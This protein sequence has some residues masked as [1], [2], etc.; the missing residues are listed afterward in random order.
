MSY[1]REKR[2]RTAAF[3]IVGFLLTVAGSQR[4][5]FDW[6]LMISLSSRD[7]AFYPALSTAGFQ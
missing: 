3:L 6:I 7:Y 4:I 2:I 1:F 5:Q